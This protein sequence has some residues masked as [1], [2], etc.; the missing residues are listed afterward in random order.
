MHLVYDAIALS[1]TATCKMLK[2]DPFVYLRDLF[3]EL[4]K[5]SNPTPEQLDFWLPDQWQLR[6]QSQ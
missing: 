6:Q 5:L 2:I 3:T 4:P 1:F